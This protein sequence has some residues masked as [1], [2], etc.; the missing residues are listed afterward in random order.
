M[1]AALLG[2]KPPTPTPLTALQPAAMAELLE[3]LGRIHPA[4]Q[5]PLHE[6]GVVSVFSPDTGIF[7]PVATAKEA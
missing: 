4:R 2:R 1:A 5:T 6:L 3:G 7:T